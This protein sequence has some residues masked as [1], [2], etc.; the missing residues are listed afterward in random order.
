M[1]TTMEA[2]VRWDRAIVGA[3]LAGLALLAWL[4]VLR[5]AQAMSDLDMHGAMGMAGPQMHDWHLAD[6]FLTFLMWS[7]M[8]AAMMIPAASPMV[9]MF[10]R[11]ARSRPA[12]AR[13]FAQTGFFV[14]GY[15]LVWATY[16]ALAT[17][18]QWGLHSAALLSPM[19]TTTSRHLGGALLIAAGIFQWTP[20]K[21]R[22]LRACRSPLAFIMGEWR[23]GSA[24]ALIMG[25]RH[26]AYC[27]G[28]CWA[29]MA[30]LFVAGVMNLIWV[31]ALA[32]FVLIEKMAPGEQWVTRV[33][34]VALVIVGTLLMTPLWR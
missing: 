15:L 26:G 29:L 9:L 16:S 28:C 34:G 2:R 30:L 11:I 23:E 25:L 1:S 3:G 18:A 20:L 17:L 14:L 7:V 8:M 4:Y 6:T 33:A 24:G 12:A 21:D 31:A 19:L 27:V 5:L 22:C 10:A 32:A 13:P